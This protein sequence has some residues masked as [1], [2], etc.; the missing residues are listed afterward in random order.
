[1]TRKGKSSA[2]TPDFEIETRL[3]APVRLVA[4]VDEVGRGCLAGSVVAAAVVFPALPV[5]EFPAWVSRVRDSK[6]LEAAER[7]ELAAAIR[8]WS[9]AWCVAEASVAEIEQLNILHASM[10]AMRRAV[11]G[12]GRP[13]NHVLVDGNRIPRGLACDATAVV[14]G[15][16]RS[17]SIAA[18]SILAKVHRDAMMVEAAV[19]YPGYG[20]EIHKAYPTPTHLEALQ[21]LGVTEIHRRAYAPVKALLARAAAG[22]AAATQAE[23]EDLFSLASS[24]SRL[25]IHSGT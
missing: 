9:A 21:R 17:L 4:G 15:D 12:L 6:Q 8:E 24:P 19:R 16:A 23:D 1:M 20:F 25:G 14:K 3:G 5:A 13:V 11:E 2:A 18:S 7:E 22:P 10:L